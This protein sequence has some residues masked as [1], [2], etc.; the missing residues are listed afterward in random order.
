MICA[1]L[2]VSC[3]SSLEGA[4]FTPQF[5]G[6]FVAKITRLEDKKYLVM[7]FMYS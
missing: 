1:M 2:R 7:L 6:G 5:T 3:V 4:Q